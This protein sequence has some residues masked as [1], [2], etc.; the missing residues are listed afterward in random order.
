MI[1]PRISI[2]AAVALALFGAGFAAGH[3]L[4]A[5]AG[6]QRLRAADGRTA[7]AQATAQAA[8]AALDAI[9]QRLDAQRAQLEQAQQAAA[10]ALT[11]RDRA[12]RAADRATQQRLTTLQETAHADPDCAAL[13]SLAV[14]PAVARR[15][16]DGADAATGARRD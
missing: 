16:L 10:A 1:A 13:A 3:R 5:R 12:R 8:N 9:R 6:A 4:E 15:V 7:T 14:C 2:A 11:E